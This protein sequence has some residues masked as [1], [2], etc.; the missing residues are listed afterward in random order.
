[1]VLDSS[2]GEP[3]PCSV[4]GSTPSFLLPVSILLPPGNLLPVVASDPQR[5][6][7]IM[8][9]SSFQ[10]S[11][12]H[13]KLYKRFQHHNH[14]SKLCSFLEVSNLCNDTESGYFC[15]PQTLEY[16]PCSLICL[17]TTFLCKKKSIIF[18]FI[19]EKAKIFKVKK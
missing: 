6:K 18:P 8:Q 7:L 13:I 15:Y 5:T 9:I 12:D 16:L 10:L 19:L 14:S 4:W 2:I 11:K 17:I 3:L 1:M